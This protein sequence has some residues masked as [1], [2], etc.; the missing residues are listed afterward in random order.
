MGN[1]R[2]GCP[3]HTPHCPPLPHT[4]PACAPTPL[5]PPRRQEKGAVLS[6]EP[7]T[8]QQWAAAAHTP[9]QAGSWLGGKNMVVP[10]RQE[11]PFLLTCCVPASWRLWRKA[12][13]SPGLTGS[14]P[15]SHF[16]EW[17]HCLQVSMENAHI[18]GT[19]QG[20]DI[21]EASNPGRFAGN[22][23]NILH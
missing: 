12:C 17:D 13:P 1:C 20:A 16:W 6:L 22:S 14:F 10:N 11:I 2:G 21:L 23:K 3:S 9:S 15:G 4:R 19:R 7:P 5:L 8:R 18:S